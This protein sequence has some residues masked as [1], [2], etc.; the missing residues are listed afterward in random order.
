MVP[1]A[2][3]HAAKAYTVP[4]WPR[5]VVSC[6]SLSISHTCPQKNFLTLYSRTIKDKVHTN[7][8]KKH[9]SKYIKCLPWFFKSTRHEQTKPTLHECLARYTVPSLQLPLLLKATLL[10]QADVHTE[11]NMHAN[12]NAHAQMPTRM[13]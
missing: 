11:E 8:S 1:A 2:V 7:L 3:L 12:T 10:H 9:Y 5:N 4:V 6:C 13:P